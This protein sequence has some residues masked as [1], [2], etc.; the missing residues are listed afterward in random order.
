MDQAS[1]DPRLSSET[2]PVS[3][4]QDQ[5]PGPLLVW[6][7][8]FVCLSLALLGLVVF[9]TLGGRLWKELGFLSRELADARNRE[10]MGYLGISAEQPE[11]KPSSCI[12]EA[13]G[14]VYLWAGTGVKGQAGWF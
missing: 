3:I 14:R 5:D 9:V 6:M 1:S 12:R 13:D 8:R 4:P 7:R 2:V 11:Y 10:P